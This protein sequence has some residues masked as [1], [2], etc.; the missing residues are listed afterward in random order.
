MDGRQTVMLILCGALGEEQAK[1]IRAFLARVEALQLRRRQG[2]R[3][4]VRG[5]GHGCYFLVML[6]GCYV[7]F[8]A[9][10]GVRKTLLLKRY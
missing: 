3:E 2:N 6:E 8:G 1:R 10:K 4:G 7:V 9:V 5:G